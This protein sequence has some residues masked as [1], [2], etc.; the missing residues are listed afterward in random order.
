MDMPPC[1]DNSA[2]S[3]QFQPPSLD[4][5]LLE[6]GLLLQAGQEPGQLHR[7]ASTQLLEE[8]FENVGVGEEMQESPCCG[9]IC[10][11]AYSRQLLEMVLS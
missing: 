9:C 4:P 5:E 1:E 11:A 8:R 10:L 7:R 6:L 2:A 3:L